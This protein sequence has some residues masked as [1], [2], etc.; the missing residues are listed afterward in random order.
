MN[1]LIKIETLLNE[2]K[3]K[4][5][6]HNDFKKEYNKQLAF[7]FSL[8]N[9]FNIGENKVSQILT[10]FLDQ[11]QNH[12]QGNIFL[13]EFIKQ[14][15]REKIDIS[16]SEVYCEKVITNNR[17]IDIYIKTEELIIAIEN[18]IWADD[19]TNQLEDYATYLEEKTNGK[20]L[21]LYLNPY[22]S[23]PTEKSISNNF[24]EQLKKKEQFK[25]IS[26]EYDIINL[27]NKWLVICEADNVTSF[28]KEFKKYLEIKFLK[29]NTLNMSKKLKE[30]IYQNEET[31]EVLINAYRKIERENIEKLNQIWDALDALKE[32]TRGVI[33][34]DLKLSDKPPHTANRK[35]VFW[36]S[37]SKGNNTIVFEFV[38][39]EI[40]L[41]S[42]YYLRNGSDKKFKEIAIKVINLDKQ[43]KLN[44][45]ESVSELVTQ[46]KLILLFLT[47]LANTDY[48]NLLL[49][50]SL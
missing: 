22:G 44:S 31:V 11:K 42:M 13:N 17:R 9:F 14:F 19:Q 8:F 12:G 3:S 49:V 34:V 16:S 7:D 21:L 18:K 32:E 37:V 36:Y 41:Y 26:Y 40:H 28:L 33:N 20:F 29:K 24:K 1:N 15:N 5:D 27:I 30:I 10:Y 23:E 4:I 45:K 50:F 47:P 6:A 35:K 48:P 39:K 38:Q 2:I 46:G 25:I 43:T